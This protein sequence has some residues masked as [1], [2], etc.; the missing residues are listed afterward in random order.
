[1]KVFI[2]HAF[3]DSAAFDNVI[4]AFKNEQIEY[5]DPTSI[6][7]GA[8]LSDQLR[9]IISSSIC[10]FIATRR[11]VAST[12]CSAELGAFWGAGKKILIYLADPELSESVLPPRFRGHFLEQRIPRLVEHVRATLAELKEPAETAPIR[13]VTFQSKDLRDILEAAFSR[14]LVAYQLRD[15]FDRIS[16][17]FSNGVAQTDQAN[18]AQLHSTLVRILNRRPWEVRDAASEFFPF[19]FQFETSTGSWQGYAQTQDISGPGHA[20]DVVVHQ[21]CVLVRSDDDG[22]WIVSLA[23]V[24]KVVEGHNRGVTATGYSGVVAAVGL[25]T[26]GNAVADQHY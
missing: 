23:I 13:G 18:V 7:S 19:S 16:Q 10:V 25:D 9:E 26:L 11:S 12:W 24:D 3:E 15:T 22:R 21:A 2:S 4:W 14:A 5:W 1:M 20:P 8:L 17:A 6:R